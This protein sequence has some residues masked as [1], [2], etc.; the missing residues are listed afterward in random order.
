MILNRSLHLSLAGLLL[1]FGL[2]GCAGTSSEAKK[3]SSA[4]DVSGPSRRDTGPVLAIVGGRRFTMRDI[5]SVLASAPPSIREEYADPEQ[6][7]SLVE[8]LAQQW[9][10]FLEA[11]R[12][13]TEA[14]PN[15][16]SELAGSQR[17][18]LMKY[19]YKNLMRA[20]PAI[21]DSAVHRYYDD[22][23]NDFKAPGRARVRHIQ[24][25]TQARAREVLKRLRSG[26]TWDQACA[27]YST[28]R[29]SSKTGGV[30]GYVTTDSDLVPVL[31]KVPSIV[32]AAFKIKE[33]ETSEPLK[34]DRGWHLIR[35]DEQTPAGAHPFKDV[36]PRIRALLEG[37]RN[38][39]FDATLQDSLKIR[40]G[41]VL[42]PDSI[43]MAH[44]PPKSPAEIFAKAQA[45][46]SPRDRIELFEGLISRFPKDKSAVQAAFMIGFTYAEEL[47]DYPAARKAFEKF[48]REHPDSDLVPSA[49]WMLENMGTGA[50]PPGLG[51]MG[52]GPTL[53]VVPPPDST[54]SKP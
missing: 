26:S 37:E 30:L 45:E 4:P 20:L 1:A 14:D 13:G 38:Q 48:M 10:L 16:R 28:D 15:Y 42:F 9:A 6:F 23:A 35:V 29:G 24:V 46:V 19:Y 32:A 33:G 18:L 52:G 12:V 49:K 43:E 22:H 3:A 39:Q 41:L 34:S 54:N 50:T 25:P 44:N 5:D 27:K 47:K 8:R 36:E 17:Q 21:P 53:E 2:W 51:P 31:G 40:Y 11:E 7:K